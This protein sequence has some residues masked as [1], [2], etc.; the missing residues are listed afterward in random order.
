MDFN[1]GDQV[2]HR[3]YGPGEILQV[4]EKQVGG[5]KEVYYIVQTSNLTLWVPIGDNGSSSLRFVT[6]AKQFKRLFALLKEPGEELPEDRLERKLQ[7]QERLKDG[8]LDAVCRVVRDL[9]ELSKKKK[10]ND[11]DAAIMERARS[12]LLNEWTI[13]FAIPLQEADKELQVL[14]KR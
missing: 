3:A 4:D 10:L 13:A 9:N 5:K 7:L 8:S 11:Y 12:F 1:V 2:I 6:P 14:L